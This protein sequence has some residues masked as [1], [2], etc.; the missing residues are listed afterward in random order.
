MTMRRRT[1]LGLGAAGAIGMSAAVLGAAP[2]HA[3][4]APAASPAPTA[5]YAIGVREYRWA[6]GG[7]SLFTKVFY[8][9]TGTPGGAPVPNAP[10]AAGVFP[11][12]EFSHGMGCNSDCYS[13]QTHGLA[14]AGFVCPAP[15]FSDNTNIG[16]VY[17]GEWSRDVSEVIT[18]TLALNGA[19]GDPLAGHIDTGAG[20]GVS[21]HSM[22][23]MTTHGLVTAWPDDR[24]AAAVPIA[25]VDMGNPTGQVTA[26][27]LFIHGDRDPTCDYNSARRAYEELPA[28]KAFLTHVGADHG[29]YLVPGF[30]T[31][32]QTENTFLDWFRWSLYGDTAARDRLPAGATANGT[33]WEAGL[34]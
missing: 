13:S 27:V 4:P 2:V 24:I 26:N 23:G 33:R 16:S 21:G 15:S 32:P 20:V 1:L 14:A 10:V 22:G 17:R 29:S 30:R 5:T 28:P 31:Y 7:R 25:C 19:S 12:V 3:H 9:A 18:R 11:V 6:R 34:G 8:P